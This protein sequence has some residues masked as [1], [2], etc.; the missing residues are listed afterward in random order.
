MVWDVEGEWKGRDQGRP[1]GGLERNKA[2]L[3]KRWGHAAPPSQRPRRVAPNGGAAVRR[4]VEA[5]PQP[6]WG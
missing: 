6:W 2:G 1:D 5:L 3:R 4:Q